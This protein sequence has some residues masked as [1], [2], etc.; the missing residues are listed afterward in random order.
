MEALA[1][2]VWV[3][4]ETWASAARGGAVSWGLEE[5]QDCEVIV[6]QSGRASLKPW[7]RGQR[8]APTHL[9]LVITN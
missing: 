9:T 2:N 8:G 1:A 5:G 6:A 7:A 3:R 4:L